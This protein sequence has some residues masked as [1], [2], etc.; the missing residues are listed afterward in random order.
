MGP[1]LFAV[2]GQ[3]LSTG[4]GFAA[5]GMAFYAQGPAQAA[6][7][8][9]GAVGVL[10]GTAAAILRLLLDGVPAALPESLPAETLAALLRT[11]LAEAQRQRQASR[12]GSVADRRPAALAEPVLGPAVAGM[13]SALARQPALAKARTPLAETAAANSNR[14]VGS[15]V[16]A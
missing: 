6:A 3:G 1:M 12:I 5:L 2:L 15:A 11:T 14:L 8:L 16:K 9:F 10:C 13:A 7:A 4:M